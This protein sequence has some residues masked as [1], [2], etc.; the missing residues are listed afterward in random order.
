MMIGLWLYVLLLVGR[1]Q[2]A[3][4]RRAARRR[5]THAQKPA[6]AGRGGARAAGARR[7]QR[8]QAAQAAQKTQRAT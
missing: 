3:F 4:V 8:A 2:R 6:P 7:Q 1:S 5:S